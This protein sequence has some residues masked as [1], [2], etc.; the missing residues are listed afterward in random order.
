MDEILSMDELGKEDIIA[1]VREAEAEVENGAELLDGKE[2][3]AKLREKHIKK[4]A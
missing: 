2:T 3:L 1:K 4:Q